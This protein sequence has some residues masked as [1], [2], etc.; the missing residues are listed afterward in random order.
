MLMNKGQYDG[1][2]VLSAQAVDSMPKMQVDPDLPGAWQGA[3]GWGYGMAVTYRAKED[4]F[5]SIGSFG[6]NGG[7]G[8]L[9]FVDPEKKLIGIIFTQIHFSNPHEL[10]EGFELLVYRAVTG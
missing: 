1:H 9:F 8:T 4:E 7:L 3:R 10:R 5:R 2:E 6:W